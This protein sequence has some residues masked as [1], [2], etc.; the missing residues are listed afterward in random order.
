MN[1]K[2]FRSTTGDVRVA[3]T[4]GHS[5][6]ISNSFVP[7]PEILWGQ[8]YMNGAISRDMRVDNLT[9]YLT[10]VATEKLEMESI[11]R[12]KYKDILSKAFND[13]VN[14]VNDDGSLIFRNVIPLFLPDLPKQSLVNEIWDLLVA[15]SDLPIVKNTPKAKQIASIASSPIAPKHRGRPPVNKTGKK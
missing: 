6:V 10:D 3:S 11:E 13:P 8:A 14:Y 2:D 7:V 5:V 15:E 9:N 1:Y 12:Q 4:S